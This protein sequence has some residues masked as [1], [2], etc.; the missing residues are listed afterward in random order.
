ALLSRHRLYLL[1]KPSF[2]ANVVDDPVENLRQVAA[3]QP[4][5]DDGLDDIGNEPACDAVFHA[6]KG[7]VERSA[8]TVVT[9]NEPE[10]LRYGREQVAV[11]HLKSLDNVQT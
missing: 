4:L 6:L 3:D 2:L 11:D 7:P 1:L 9:E 5:D 8:Q 10:L